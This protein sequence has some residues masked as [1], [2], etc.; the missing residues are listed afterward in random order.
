[1]LKVEN[2][3]KSFG[4]VKA[5]QGCSFGVKPN[6]ITALIGPNGA[7]KSTVFNLISGIVKPD[8]GKIIFKAGKQVSN[9]LV[10]N[11]GINIIGK[12]PEIISNLGMSRLFQK[13]RLFNNLTVK[14]NL[15]LAIDNEDTK[16][17]FAFVKT[18]ANKRNKFEGRIKEI[19]KL[20]EM[21]NFE[22][23]TSRDL[24]FGQKRLVELARAIL[25]PHTFLML[26]EPVAGVN[27]KL[28][29]VIA[30]I[31]LDL[32]AKQET[33][34]LI[35]HDMNFTFSVADWIIVM[36]EGRVLVEGAPADIKN[37]PKVLEAYLGE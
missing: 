13:S 23:Y 28:R 14:E 18:S 30:K 5:A 36:Q 21:E 15:L 7:G 20:V 11:E 33:I 26:D 10:S 3:Y 25:N 27:P 12:S 6:L 1:M 32:K 29:E 2:I 4:G 22:N 16:F 19:L 31:L 34:L 37:N 8:A 9:K 35:E 24:S 17:W